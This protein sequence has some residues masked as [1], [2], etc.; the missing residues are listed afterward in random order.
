MPKKAVAIYLILALIGAALFIFFTFPRTKDQI[1]TSNNQRPFPDA[2]TAP[3]PGSVP[4]PETPPHP[5]SPAPQ[6]GPTLRV[7]A[8]ASPAEAQALSARLDDYAAQTGWS[9]SIMLVNDEATYRQELAGALAANS[10]PDVCLID[11][12]DFSGANPASDFASVPADPASALRS[13]EAF[14]VDGSTRAFPAE[15]SVD[16]LYYNP[17]A[18]DRA[19]IAAPGPHWNWDMLEAMS[20]A[21]TSLKLKT[22]QGAPIYA[23]EL[24][25]DFDFWNM[26]CTQ[27]GHPA[28]DADTWHVADADSKDAELRSLDFIHTFFQGLSVT[29]P[30]T[31]DGSGRY[32]G[33]QQAAM[34]IGPSELVAHLPGFAYQI[35]DL[36]RDMCAASLARVNGWA[37]T[38]RSSQADAARSLAIFLAEQPLHAGWTSTRPDAAKD[39]FSLI[40]QAALSES[41]IPRLGAKDAAL[42]HF[43]DDQIG[44]FARDSNGDTGQLYTRIQAEYQNDFPRSGSAKSSDTPN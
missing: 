6:H 38:T 42:A 21:I 15:F 20:R 33:Q 12:R 16:L 19:G 41:V 26:L 32:F 29:A 28:L 25:A 35:T 2:P 5:T 43:L 27:A 8:W 3:S 13:L 7:M 23:L 36:P 4:V 22:G 11:A 9:A 18:F 14:T 40:C 34:L 1:P 30:L 31:G 10:P 39:G 17:S 37:V 44:H 24:P